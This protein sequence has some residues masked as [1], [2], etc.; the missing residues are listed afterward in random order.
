VVIGSGFGARVVAPAWR[1]HGAHVEV[2]S[3]RADDLSTALRRSEPHI[4]SV[5]SPPYQHETHVRLGIDAGAFVLCDKPTTPSSTTTAELIETLG[6]GAQRVAVNF[7]FRFEPARREMSRHLRSGLIG[8]VRRVVWRHRSAGSIEPMRPYGW[9]FDASLGGGWIG[10][11][12]SHAVDALHCWLGAPLT[13]RSSEPRIDVPVRF[14]TNGV[15]RDVTAEDG[16]IA[17]LESASGVEIQIDSSF[18]STHPTRPKIVIEGS[19]GTMTNY[20]DRRLVID[21]PS[22]VRVGTIEHTYGSA[23]GAVDRHAAPMDAMVTTIMAHALGGDTPDNGGVD[24]GP[25]S[26]TKF[27]TLADGLRVDRVLDQLRAGRAI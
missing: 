22:G 5:H 7:E 13:V 26:V 24:V 19:L 23:T 16:L 3:S 20:A 11:W 6:A 21:R 25:A 12:A 1:S 4:V 18:A 8:E 9:L 17:T 10:A 14:D 15:A 27:A 2:L